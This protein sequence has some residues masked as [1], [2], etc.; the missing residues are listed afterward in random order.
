LF[1]RFII[2]KNTVL[3]GVSLS[4]SFVGGGAMSDPSKA[5]LSAANPAWRRT[6][7]DMTLAGGGSAIANTGAVRRHLHD[8]IQPYR[9]LAP[10]PYGGMYLN[11]ADYLEDEWQLAFW[12]SDESDT[13]GRYE[14]LRRIKNEIDP[15]ALLVVSRG[16]G[17]EDWDEQIICRVD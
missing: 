3:T 13:E 11:E 16:V 4:L 10:P 15:S 8:E 1:L 17:S 6:I 14:K 5:A 7:T 9:A 12:G 2:V